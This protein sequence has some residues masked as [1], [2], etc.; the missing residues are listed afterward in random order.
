MRPSED[1][2]FKLRAREGEM[3]RDLIAKRPQD[4]DGMTSALEQIGLAQHHGLKTRLVDV[5]RNPLVAL[6]S[7]CDSRDAAG[8]SHPNDMDGRIHVFALPKE[9]I[10]SF[11]SDN[12]SIIS[13]L[14]E[15]GT[16]LS[17]SS[18]RGKWGRHG[19]RRPEASDSD[20]AFGGPAP[21]ISLHSAREAAI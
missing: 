15:I 18:G 21:L 17:K 4:F 10:R 8:I 7:A 5:S 9:A 6:F 11:D 3:P 12:V 2:G 1:G 14:C 16:K 13:K 19:G 20:R